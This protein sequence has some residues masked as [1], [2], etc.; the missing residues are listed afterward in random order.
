MW[1]C[2]LALDLRKLPELRTP[3]GSRE[4]HPCAA[5][6]GLQEFLR[7]HTVCWVTKKKEVIVARTESHI[8]SRGS[9]GSRRVRVV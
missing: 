6:Q 1:T 5:P 7:G 4:A 8:G 2:A 3:D 9:R